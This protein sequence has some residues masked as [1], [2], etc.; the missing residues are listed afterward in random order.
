[1]PYLPATTIGA[2]LQQIERKELILPA[3]QREYV[4]KPRQVVALFDS[5]MR[6]YPIGNF[7]AWKVQPSTIQTFRFYDFLRSYSE[8]DQRHNPELSLQSDQSVIAILD[9]QQRLTSLNI[10]LRGT[11]AWKNKYAWSGYRENYP[12]RILH[13]NVRGEAPENPAGLQFDF[14]FLSSR[15]LDEMGTDE[16]RYWLPVTAVYEAGGVMGL[17]EILSSRELANDRTASGIASRLA[18][19][20][21]SDNSVHMYEETDQD[22]ERVLDIFIRVNSGGTVLSYSDL[23]LSIATAQWKDRDARKEIHGLV[24][25]LNATGVGFRLSK[26]LVLKTALVLSGVP[27]VAFKVKNFTSANMATLNERWDDIANALRLAVALLSDFGLS[28]KS[29]TAHSIVIPLAMYIQRR[30]LTQ[31]YRESAG[32]APDRDLLKSWVMRALIVPGIW[33]SG[34]DQLL[35]ALRETIA[36]HGARSFPVSEIDRMMASRGKSLLA[37]DELI[38]SILEYSFGDGETFGILA[39]AF[40]HVNTRNIHHVDHIFPRARLSRSAL[41]RAGLDEEVIDEIL[42]K[43]DKLPNLELLEGPENAAKNAKMPLA[44][45]RSVYGSEQAYSA[46]LDR[47]ALPDLS[48]EVT[49]FLAFYDARRALLKERVRRA[50]GLDASADSLDAGVEDAQGRTVPPLEESIEAEGVEESL[51]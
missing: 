15:Q 13:L 32:E 18:E 43:R 6:G 27:D 4:W 10:G 17:W 25:E 46:Y 24:D 33:G 51:L 31:S 50:F 1:M 35:R 16:A 34:L 22:I 49:D 41:H 14:R 47:N 39:I 29:L 42:R 30:Q 28:G 38:D 3:I 20:I 9:G 12:P 48:D 2:T 23:L 11:Y 36:E 21:H 19:K 37:S 40:P 44:W 45:S 26:D 7:L 5:I 8:L